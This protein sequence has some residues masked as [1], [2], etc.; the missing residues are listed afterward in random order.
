MYN[1]YNVCA[2]ITV[3]NTNSAKTTILTAIMLIPIIPGGFV[4]ALEYKKKLQVKINWTWMRLYNKKIHSK[5]QYD[6]FKYNTGG[7][8]LI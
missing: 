6:I 5:L 2:G 4:M 1:I 7:C 3:I 8:E